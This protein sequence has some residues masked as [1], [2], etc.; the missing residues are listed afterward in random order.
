M[1]RLAIGATA[2]V[3][4]VSAAIYTTALDQS[5]PYLMHDELQFSLQAR[6]IAATGH[7]LAGRWLPVYFTEPEFPAGRDPVIIYYT[8][9]W[10][11]VLPFSQAHV[12]LPTA[13]LGVVNVGLMFAAGWLLFGSPWGGV[14][15]AALLAFTPIHFIRARMVL[16]PFY[17]VPFVL[18]WLIALTHYVRTSSRRALIAAAACSTLSVY[19]YLA[20]TVMAPLYLLITLI[21]ATAREGRKVV[22]PLVGTVALLLLPLVIW[23][24][25]HPER[26]AQL[27]DAYRLYGSGTTPAPMLA[28]GT[29]TGPRVWLRLLWQFLNPD[30]LF[31]SGDSSMVN[32][33][34]ASGLFPMAF[35]VLLR[36]APGRRSSHGI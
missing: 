19:T 33:T 35:A 13:I 31:I 16:S 1:H 14:L 10:L 5:P 6:A 4:I 29:P 28:P 36:L 26:Y 17:S 23:S 27:I 20:C 22:L 3:L 12:K 15:A 25:T 2:L 7:D 8:A 9:A 11:R 18:G 32:S 21:I 24:L 34:R 30:F